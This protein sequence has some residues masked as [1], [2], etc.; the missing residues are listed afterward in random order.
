M[1]TSSVT[2]VPAIRNELRHMVMQ[3][4]ELA[5]YVR[6]RLQL[7]PMLKN[8]FKCGRCYAKTS[9]FLYH[10]LSEDGTPDTAGVRELFGELV[11]KLQPAH[12]EFFKKWDH[13]LTR[14]ESEMFKFKRELWTMLSHER[15]KIGR[16]FAE[17]VIEPG[18]AHEQKDA[19]KI[20]RFTY[21]LIK[22]SAGPGFSF[23]ES[24]ITT[25]EPIVVS[26]EQGHFALAN[27][28]VTKVS[29]KRIGIAVDRRLHNARKRQPGFDKFTNQ[30]FAAIMEVGKEGSQPYASLDESEDPVVYRLDKDEFSNGMAT[31]RNNL[32]ALMDDNIYRSHELR[33]LIVGNVPPVFTPTPTAYTL[34][35]PASQ[36][37]INPDQRAAIDKV[38]SAQD[39]ALVLGMPGTGK[40][41]T[42]AHIIRALVARG[43]SVLLTSYT[44]T[45]VDN[46][47]LKL[48]DSDMSILRLGVLAKI[49]PEVQD[50]ANLAA[51]PRHSIEELEEMYMTPQVVATTC[52]GVGHQIF[53]KRV[54][55]YCIVDEASQ[56]TLPVCLG[57]I[58]M[59]RTFVLV[60]DH[61]QLPPLV[62]NKEAQ[63]G[64]LDVSLFKLLSD[65]QPTSVVN[66]EH[67]YRMCK[68]IMLLSNTLIYSG[69]LKCGNEAVAQRTLLLPNPD[70]LQQYHNQPQHASSISP[71]HSLCRG[72]QHNNRPC[73]LTPVL[74]P[75]KKVLFLNT[76]TIVPLPRESAQGNRI[77]NPTEASLVSHTVHAL[78]ASGI[79]ASEI[80][81][82]T[83][84]RSQLALLRQSLK[85]VGTAEG[86]VEMHT[87]DKFQ[88]RDKEVVILSCVR[89]NDGAQ[90]GELLKDW[91]RV[92]VALTRA[93]SKLIVVGS[94]GTLGA[95]NDTLKGF[96]KLV[97]EQEWVLDLPGGAGVDH[98]GL[99][100]GAGA[101]AWAGVGG[102]QWSPVVKRT[103]KERVK[104]EKEKER[105]APKRVTLGEGVGVAN[106]NQNPPFKPVVGAGLKRPDK[107]GMMGQKTL[108]KT[109]PVLKDIVSEVLGED[110]MG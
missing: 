103:E 80:G 86:M 9:C 29:A 15:E 89:S 64:G 106:R 33:S 53:H 40:T 47:L 83:F 21:T 44:H 4:N 67:Q 63:E 38:M 18:S 92:N 2:R 7:P 82:I 8:P 10:K 68:E 102:T 100:V 5:S 25:G 57:P 60:G 50:F 73:W 1:E 101:G 66:L 74:C 70:G 95:G 79:P 46:I 88:G 59:A 31:V 3:R 77:T 65:R 75:S 109:R 45:A 52:L 27:G 99:G 81:I 22:K 61:Y 24:Q 105:Y 16:C 56:I 108:L 11:G 90:V 48:R 76:D 96:L 72:P 55:D 54:F 94:A 43:K 14:E 39:Y 85:H 12:Q 34:S 84:Y 36:L 6:E 71:S 20:N 26:S 51:E 78:L 91:R 35:G 87:A 17:V 58:R 69:R 110:G 42:I 98:E 93:R 19:Q 28:Y 13:L 62:Q 107:V 37:Q 23:T 32:L 97:R 41:T 30:A 49:H 104:K